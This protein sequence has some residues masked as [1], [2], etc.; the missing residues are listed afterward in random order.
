MLS[1]SYV[2]VFSFEELVIM[3]ASQKG[4]SKDMLKRVR[5]GPELFC[6][7][8]LGWMFFFFCFLLIFGLL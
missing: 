4:G 8:D 3:F 5:R 6:E 7:W 2:Y 1:I